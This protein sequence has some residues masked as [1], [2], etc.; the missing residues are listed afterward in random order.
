MY[1]Q[2]LV[3]SY[4]E[5]GLVVPLTALSVFHDF[6]SEINYVLLSL[7]FYQFAVSEMLSIFSSDSTSALTN[8][9]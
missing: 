7:I 1:N 2:H 8:K 9:E 6:Y 3:K 4:T 5:L